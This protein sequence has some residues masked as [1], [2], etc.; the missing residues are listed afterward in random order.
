MLT[1]GQGREDF[2]RDFLLILNP[3]N[4]LVLGEMGAEGFSF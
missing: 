3:K 4:C 1:V 2:L